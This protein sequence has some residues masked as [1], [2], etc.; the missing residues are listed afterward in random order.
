MKNI[1]FIIL[2]GLGF[3]VNFVACQEDEI[4]F[5]TGPV[6]INM[7]INEGDGTFVQGESDQEKVFK[8]K[9]S[10][11][12]DISKDRVLQLAFGEQHTAVAGTNFDLPMSVN[13]EA[14]RQDTIIECKVYRTGLTK[15]PLFFDLVVDPTGDFVGGVDDELVVKL[16]I[17]FPTQ[18][19]D[20]TG[21]AAEYY[22][23]ECTQAKYQ[24]VFE[25]LGTL[26]LTEYQGSWGSGYI[27]LADKLNKILQE[28]NPPLL[29]D[30][31][32]VMKFGNGY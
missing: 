28:Q 18:W 5:Y 20:P 9:L 16:M 13:I 15:E 23:G 6:A 8:I 3:V 14:G 17:G 10:V 4:D 22:L 1:C 26:D 32:S 12:G 25:Q 11:Q 19:Q 24:F 2:L 30:D 27:A 29:D 7:A 21:W 31:G